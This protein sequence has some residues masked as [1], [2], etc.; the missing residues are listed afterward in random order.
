M[1][2]YFPDSPRIQDISEDPDRTEV[3]SVSLSYIKPKVHSTERI[4]LGT[5]VG[6]VIFDPR[7][8]DNSHWTK[9]CRN[10]KY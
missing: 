5:E 6:N 1:A 10:M 2:G 8:V 4:V 9:S 7:V 3:E